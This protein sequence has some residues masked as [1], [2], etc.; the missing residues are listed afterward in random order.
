LRAPLWDELSVLV[1]RALRRRGLTAEEVEL[2]GLRSQQ[3]AAD[4]KQD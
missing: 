2:L 1:R 4:L 3:A